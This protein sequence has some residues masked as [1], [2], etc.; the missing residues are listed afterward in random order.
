MNRFQ[1]IL[2]AMILAVPSITFSASSTQ[3]GVRL[4]KN[5]FIDAVTPTSTFVAGSL[6]FSDFDSGSRTDLS[7][8]GGMPINNDIDFGMQWRHI[9]NDLDGADETS[10]LNALE[11]N[12]RYFFK[13]PNSPI[14]MSAVGLITLPVGEKKVGGDQFNFGAFAAARYPV[15]DNLVITANLGL[16]SLDLPKGREISVHMAAGTIFILEPKVGLIGEL[17]IQ[18]EEEYSALSV[19]ADYQLISNISVRPALAVGLDDGA[20]DLELSAELLIDF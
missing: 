8:K 14:S 12:S 7:T 11:L 6:G 17:T 2:A 15:Q 1:F 16:L 3:D 18:T 9:S 13:I 4:I 10:G 20:P 5:F 19:G